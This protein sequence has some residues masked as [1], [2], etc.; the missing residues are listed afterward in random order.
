MNYYDV[1]RHWTKR[2][3]P[4]LGDV[5]LNEILRRDFSRYMAKRG[6]SDELKPGETPRQWETCMWDLDHY[7]PEPR[8]WQYV[9]HGACHWLANFNLRLAQLIEPNREWRIITSGLHS[10]VW[11][12]ANTL[13]ELTYLALGITPDECFSWADFG[14]RCKRLSPGEYLDTAAF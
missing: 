2:I 1:K 4:H 5:E 10:T 8:Y 14:G 6:W 12:G 9:K 13:F 3:M 7:G 11:D